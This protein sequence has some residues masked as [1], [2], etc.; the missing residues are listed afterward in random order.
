MLLSASCRLGCLLFFKQVVESVAPTHLLLHFFGLF[1]FPLQLAAPKSRVWPVLDS[2]LQQVT[3]HPTS[4]HPSIST[5]PTQSLLPFI[6]S[7]TGFILDCH[8]VSELRHNISPCLSLYST[9][10]VSQTHTNTHTHSTGTSTLPFLFHNCIFLPSSVLAFLFLFSISFF[11]SINKT[12]S[13]YLCSF[14]C[15]AHCNTKAFV[16][17]PP[18]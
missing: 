15:T 14:C 10:S 8:S 2:S 12:L 16:G 7:C 11:P 18:L 6:S 9:C 3:Q 1:F 5:Q 17:L 4:L 13:A